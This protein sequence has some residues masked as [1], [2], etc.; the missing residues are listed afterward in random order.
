MTD[1]QYCLSF[2]IPIGNWDNFPI[3]IPRDGSSMIW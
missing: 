2:T 1:E 3:G